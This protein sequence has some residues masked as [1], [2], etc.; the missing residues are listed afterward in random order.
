MIPQPYSN[1][2]MSNQPEKKGFYINIVSIILMLYIASLIIFKIEYYY[3]T[4]ILDVI[5]LGTFIFLF[6]TKKL[7]I[8]KINKVIFI[9]FLFSA[10]SLA[11][12]FWAKGFNVAMFQSFQL[13]SITINMFLIYNFIKNYDIDNFFIYGILLGSFANFIFLFGVTPSPFDLYGDSTRLA[14]TVGNA[15]ALSI[16]MIMSIFVSIIYLYKEKKSNIIIYNYQYVN[17]FLSLYLIILSMSKKGIVFGFA[18][19]SIYILSTIKEIKSLIR[20]VIASMIGFIIFIYF[21]DFNEFWNTYAAI[22]HRFELFDEGLSSDTRY[23]STGWRRYFIE[24]GL[25]L[26]T[27][28]PIFGYGLN[29]FR[30]YS[31]GFYAH[32]NYIELLVGTGLVGV[33]LFYSIY[34]YLFQKTFQLYNT[35]LKFIFTFFLIILLGMDMAAGSYINKYIMYTLLFISIFLEK[36]FI[37][38]GGCHAKK[39]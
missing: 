34:I 11:T 39:N 10:F 9:Y 35:N 27:N 18:L 22:E 37:I 13:F 36:S 33:M 15:N 6:L 4:Y 5:L 21:V 26:F 19:V 3:I 2:K 25:K 29:N 14:G 17:I 38:N 23:S 1:K 16:V 7:R 31:G 20:L 32:N 30:F 8:Y 24:L 28:K 12:S